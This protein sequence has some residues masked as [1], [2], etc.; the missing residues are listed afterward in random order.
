MLT[1]LVANFLFLVSAGVILCFCVVAKQ[2]GH[3]AKTISNVAFDVLLN[4]FPL[5]GRCSLPTLPPPLP[6]AL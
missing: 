6:C 3:N 4:E 5:T 2:Q 1:F